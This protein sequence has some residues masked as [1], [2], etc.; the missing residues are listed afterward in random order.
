MSNLVKN[1][2]VNVKALKAALQNEFQPGCYDNAEMLSDAVDEF[3][4][5]NV[6][7]LAAERAAQD[8]GQAD[9]YEIIDNVD[10]FR[11]CVNDFLDS[12]QFER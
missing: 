12:H 1:K 9:I 10:E 2:I 11:D 7:M 3:V 4:Q 5:I 6:E 8:H